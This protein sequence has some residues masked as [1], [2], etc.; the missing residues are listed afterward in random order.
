LLLCCCVPLIST[1]LGYNMNIGS[2]S[3]GASDDQISQL[4]SWRFKVAHSN[5][6]DLDNDSQC[7]ERLIR[8][9]PVSTYIH[10]YT[11]TYYLIAWRCT[12]NID[13]T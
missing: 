5:N 1:L 10:T 9:E 7:S 2:S 12:I 3:K 6:L 8:E 11:H 4:L 13:L